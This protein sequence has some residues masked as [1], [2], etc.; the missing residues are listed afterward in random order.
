MLKM[1]DIKR[2]KFAFHKRLDNQI[3]IYS[4]LRIL[5]NIYNEVFGVVFVP[6]FVSCFGIMVIQSAFQTIKLTGKGGGS[7]VL[8][9]GLAAGG[10]QI[11]M[12]IIFVG[13]TAM[14]HEYSCKFGIYLQRIGKYQSSLGRRK[15]R[16]IKLIAISCGGM[17][18][19]KRI[20]CLTMLGLISNVCGSLLMYV[21]I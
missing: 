19:I 15:I 4:K 11:V 1:M 13:F 18:D 16:A 12:L 10:F 20:T 9:F 5:T 21:E 14:V 2:R 3:L 8:S 6:G 7:L 17:F